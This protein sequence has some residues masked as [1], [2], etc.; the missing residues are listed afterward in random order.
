MTDP[1][2]EPR[3]NEEIDRE[4]RIESMKQELERIAGPPVYSGS[5]APV[6]LEMEEAFLERL[7]AY[8]RADFGTNYD[9]LVA[10]GIV[11]PPPA[12]LDDA[13]LKMKLDEV[14]RALAG[15][16][17]F[18]YDTNHL[19]DR[20]LYAWLYTDG[21]REEIAD[22]SHIPAGAYHTSP[23]GAGNDEDTQ[24]WLKYYASDE[25]RRRWHIEFPSDVMPR[26]ERLPFARDRHLPK[27]PAI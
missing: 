3:D 16:R 12:E 10:Q 6:S 25:E 2:P 23:I 5:L 13:T 9:R 4:I 26:Q 1:F 20:E 11:M 27:R 14:I 18:L 24:I 22:L 8:E 15:L 19:S 17:C 21:L 7:L